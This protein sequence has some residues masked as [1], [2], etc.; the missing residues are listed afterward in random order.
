MRD[1]MAQQSLNS[2]ER[3][4]PAIFNLVRLLIARRHFDIYGRGMNME[5]AEQYA[6]EDPFLEKIN[7]KLSVIGLEGKIRLIDQWDWRYEFSLRDVGRDRF[8]TDINSLSSGQK[9]IMHLIFEAYGRGE[10]KGGIVVIDEP[11]IHLHYQFQSEYLRILQGLQV[12]QDAQYVI[13]THSESLIH[14]ETIKY[15]KRFSL[16]AEGL[17]VM[18]APRLTFGQVAKIR[19]LD[20]TRSTYSFFARRVLLVEGDTD[21]YFYRAVLEALYPKSSQEIAVLNLN[22][23]GNQAEWRALFEAYGLEVHYGGDFDNV[24]TLRNM[25]GR[26]IID[27]S[28]VE[29]ARE[30]LRQIKLNGM[31]ATEHARFEHHYQTLISQADFLTRP[32]LF[33]WRRLADAFD[34]LSAAPNKEVVQQVRLAH[35]TIEQEIEALYSERNYIL[36]RGSIE[37]YTG[38]AHAKLQEIITFCE[39]GFRTWLEGADAEEIR[40]IAAMVA[41]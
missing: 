27:R 38:T 18:H 23:K 26:T 31:T 13:V 33:P 24:F 37:D 20:N 9:A 30:H 19:I 5:Q 12:E 40:N 6:N 25:N 29:A 22:G 4:E 41:H 1:V 16:D 17:T 21:R 3:G 36:K 35:P 15:V 28:T 7:T 34:Q 39:T 2:A 8:L 11:E 32:Q 14:S 10:L